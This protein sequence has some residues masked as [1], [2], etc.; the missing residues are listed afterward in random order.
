L[1]SHSWSIVEP[2]LGEDQNREVR[3]LIESPGLTAK[4]LARTQTGKIKL[5]DLRSGKW[6]TLTESEIESLLLWL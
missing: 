1:A 4:R 6:Q 2:E 5:G 3:R